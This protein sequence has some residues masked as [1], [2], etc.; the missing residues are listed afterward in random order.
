MELKEWAKLQEELLKSQIGVLRDYLKSVEPGE[1]E[2]KT[3][4]RKSRSN[5]SIVK[6]LLVTANTPLHVSEIIRRAN[7]QYGVA[8]DRES[9]VS[10]L[11]K[12]VKKGATFIR[13]GPNTFGLKE[14]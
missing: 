8:L 6:D 4:Q 12:K 10:A 13:T 11:T 2:R 3:S 14:L 5:M 7:E 9:L 1:H